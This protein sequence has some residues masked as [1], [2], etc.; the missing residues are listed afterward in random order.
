MIKYIAIYLGLGVLI[1]LIIDLIA[2]A[3]VR[4]KIAKES[5]IRFDLTT[6]AVTT[7]FW[8]FAIIIMAFIIIKDYNKTE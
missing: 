5:D 1:N 6:K 4:R 7:L 2:D 3:I 8:P